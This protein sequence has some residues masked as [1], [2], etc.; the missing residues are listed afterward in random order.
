M[1]SGSPGNVDLS[2]DGWRQHTTL[3]NLAGPGELVNTCQA[4]IDRPATGIRQGGKMKRLIAI[5]TPIFLVSV[6]TTVQPALSVTIGRQDGGAV[7]AE[8]QRGRAYGIFGHCGFF[9]AEELYIK[10]TSAPRDGFGLPLGAGLFYFVNR[11]AM[12]GIEV[13]YTLFPEWVHLWGSHESWS[14][15]EFGGHVKFCSLPSTVGK[16]YLKIGLKMARLI[17]TQTPGEGLFGGTEGSD[18]DISTPFAP[19]WEVAV[20]LTGTPTKNH[21]ALYFE[22]VFG[23]VHLKGKDVTVSGDEADWGYPSDLTSFGANVGILL[24]L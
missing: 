23:Y 8:A 20:G 17:G 16:G 22:F 24:S 13:A 2:L 19:G 15:V 11:R 12:V 6:F 4:S 21:A 5:L 14:I 9:K 3:M 18:F 7:G 1:T 10:A